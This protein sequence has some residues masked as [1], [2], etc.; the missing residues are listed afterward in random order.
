MADTIALLIL[1]AVCTFAGYGLGRI[2]AYRE[3]NRTLQEV[4]DYVRGLK[5]GTALP[6]APIQSGRHVKWNQS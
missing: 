6:D 3:A 5:D 4:L 1:C 2:S